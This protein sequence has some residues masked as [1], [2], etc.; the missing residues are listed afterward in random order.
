GLPDCGNGRF[1]RN[2]VQRAILRYAER[3][4]GGG[5]TAGNGFALEAADFE[6]PEELSGEGK[7]KLGFR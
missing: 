5:G 6:M 3:V 1:C 7:V 2:M 4:Y